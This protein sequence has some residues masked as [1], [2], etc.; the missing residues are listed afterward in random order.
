[1]TPL[2]FNAAIVT[3]A[4]DL[5]MRDLCVRPYHNHPKGCPNFGKR[6]TCPPKQECYPYVYD[7]N[8]RRVTWAL[9]AEFDLGSH[10]RRM[11]KRHPL[12]TYRQLSCCRY[13]QGTVRKFLRESIAE[14]KEEHLNLAVTTCPEAMGVNVTATMRDIG[15]ELEWP[16]KQITRLIYLAGV[17]R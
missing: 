15:V 7:T 1:M 6:S 3:P 12:W 14:W 17:L 10:V 11:R 8:T 16:P 2:K 13:W 5:G 4:I 9:W